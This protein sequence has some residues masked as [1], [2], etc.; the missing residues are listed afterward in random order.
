[1]SFAPALRAW[2][3]N[4]FISAVTFSG[5]PNIDAS[6]VSEPGPG[7][8]PHSMASLRLWQPSQG[9]PLGCVMMFSAVIVL[10]VMGKLTDGGPVSYEQSEQR[11]NLLLPFHWPADEDMANFCHADCLFYASLPSGLLQLTFLCSLKPQTRSS[12]TNGPV[13]DLVEKLRDW[14]SAWFVWLS[15]VVTS[16]SFCPFWRLQRVSSWQ[17]V[18]PFSEQVWDPDMD[19]DCVRVC[20]CMHRFM[21]E[22]EGPYVQVSPAI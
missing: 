17:T 9:F 20:R 15:V 13:R 19:G 18:V 22:H 8:G 11:V 12:K 4:L 14:S 10:F 21:H 7:M 5:A 3:T 1:M 2:L 16:F 6:R